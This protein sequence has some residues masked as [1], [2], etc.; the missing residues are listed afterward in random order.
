MFN[1]TAILWHLLTARI[2][3]LRQR[4]ERGEITTTVI[5]TAMMAIAAIAIVT[6]IIVKLTSK[7]NS[8]DLGMG[9]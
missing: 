5:V 2:I 7:A 1:H 4:P 3:R 9:F 8:I 6:I